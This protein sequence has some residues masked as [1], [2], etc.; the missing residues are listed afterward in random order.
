[1]TQLGERTQ[2][3]LREHRRKNKTKDQ[4]HQDS[5]NRDVIHSL[6][7]AAHVVALSHHGVLIHR[8][9]LICGVL[10]LFECGFQLGEIKLLCRLGISHL[11]K[12]IK[13]L[14]IVRPERAQ[15][16]SD[17]KFSRLS[18]IV[19]LNLYLGSDQRRFRTAWWS[20]LS[21]RPAIR[22]STGLS[23]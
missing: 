20:S 23:H 5:P 18:D 3:P 7:G 17:L 8:Q 21:R 2:Q 15:P 4:S 12:T 14:L 19:L 11:L 1:M 13:L 9:N 6:R 16:L 22:K 10:Y